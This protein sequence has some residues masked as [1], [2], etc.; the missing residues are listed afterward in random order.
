MVMIAPM[1]F[2]LRDIQGAACVF[3]ICVGI[4]TNYRRCMV[5]VASYDISNAD[6]TRTLWWRGVPS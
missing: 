3:Q 5:D 2:L 1:L 4:K 6:A